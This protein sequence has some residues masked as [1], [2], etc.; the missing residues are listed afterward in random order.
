MI[1]DFL[2]LG[3]QNPEV[4]R[5]YEACKR[6]NPNINLLGFIDNDP[7]KHGM[8]FCG[9]KV[10]GGNDILLSDK[11]K[12][13]SV[14]NMVT[15]N[16]LNRREATEQLK[17]FTNN[18]ISLIH[19]SIDLSYTKLGTGL[20]IQENVVLQYDVNIK[21]HVSIHIGTLVGHE[22]TIGECSF[23]AHGCSISG[24]VSIGNN[25]TFG[26]GVNVLPRIKI[27]DN[28]IIGGGTVIIKDI[29]ANSVVVGNP[30][31]IIKTLQ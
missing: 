2:M 12:N 10:L 15:S 22:T 29:P 25:V 19:P 8:D 16:A 11:Y 5:L 3:A 14:I 7:K 17:Q 27:G 31:R 23:I 9:Y 21:D 26:V 30:A 13:I 24:I 4:I 6:N 20:Y 1:K 28:C 18:F